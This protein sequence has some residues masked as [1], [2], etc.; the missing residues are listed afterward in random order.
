MD[1]L[2]FP[3]GSKEYVGK[4]NKII[5]FVTKSFYLTENHK[6]LDKPD[7]V[8]QYLAIN[9]AN[10]RARKEIEFLIMKSKTIIDEE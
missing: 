3:I 8:R 6:H 9:Q 10:K 2:K 5:N 1:F 4:K 7:L